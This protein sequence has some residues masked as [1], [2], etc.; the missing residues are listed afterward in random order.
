VIPN[1]ALIVTCYVLYRLIETTISAVQRNRTAGIVLGV[2]AGICALVV[3]SL[4]YGIVST[5][6]HMGSGLPGQ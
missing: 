2:F 6:S 3:S 1:L 4:A 5:G